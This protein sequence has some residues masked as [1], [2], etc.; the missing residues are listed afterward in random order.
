MR[1]GQSSKEEYPVIVFEEVSTL[2]RGGHIK[3]KKLGK[4]G[5]N[6]SQYESLKGKTIAVEIGWI[7]KSTDGNYRYYEPATNELNPTF[8]EDSLEKLKDKINTHR[9]NHMTRQKYR[10]YA[11]LSEDISA[12]Y[13]WASNLPIQQRPI[14]KITNLDTNSSVV[15]QVLRVD[16]NFR[17][18]YNRSPNTLNLPATDP[19]VVMNKWYRSRLGITKEFDSDLE[20]GPIWQWFHWLAEIQA[21][22]S[23]PDHNIRLAV[24]L[25]LLSVILGLVGLALGII[26]L[27]R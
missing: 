21:S 24:K 13:I 27:Y 9:S 16:Q 19:V 25:A 11:A 12:P 4:V 6:H 3:V 14:A 5:Q 8:V 2:G 26:S 23:H 17:K 15:C 18:K 1:I 22:Y 20:I 7:G 10:V